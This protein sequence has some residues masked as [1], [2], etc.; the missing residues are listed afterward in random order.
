MGTFKVN[1]RQDEANFLEDMDWLNNISTLTRDELLE[2]MA[3]GDQMERDRKNLQVE[4]EK[5]SKDI[6]MTN[7]ALSDTSS[8]L[9]EIERSIKLSEDIGAILDE[10]SQIVNSIDT[11]SSEGEEG[12]L[13]GTILKISTTA[14]AAL[15][16]LGSGVFHAIKTEEAYSKRRQQLVGTNKYLR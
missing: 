5:I 12:D 15:H 11:A 13:I 9:D 1:L 3:E 7:D 16:N 8:E 10:A 14:F 4:I 6:N 2:R